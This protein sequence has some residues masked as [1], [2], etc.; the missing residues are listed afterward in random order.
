[1]L[2]LPISVWSGYFPDLSIEETVQTFLKEGFHHSEFGNCHLNQ[3]LERGISA[4]RAGA[5]IAAYAADNGFS[6]P[7]GH[8]TYLMGLCGADSLDILKRDIDLFQAMGIQN[9]VLH[10]NGGNE[11]PPEARHARRLADVAELCEYVKG[12]DLILCLENLGSV[13]ETHTA[14][15]LIGIIESIGSPNLGICLDTGHLHLVN[16]RKEAQQ[17]FTEFIEK[18]GTL[19]RAL[20]IHDNNAILDEHQMPFS[21]RYG[22]NWAEFMQALRNSSFRGL[23]NLEIPGERFTTLPIRLSKLHFARQLVD[24]MLSD[25]FIEAYRAGGYK[26]A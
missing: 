22:I 14:E 23:F 20:H 18:A 25:H 2:N 15:R 7:Q 17:T 8:L 10:F 4:E 5:A 24:E 1:M 9:A 13:P 3:A 16:G 26:Q 11:L 21:A 12:T 6:F 19:L